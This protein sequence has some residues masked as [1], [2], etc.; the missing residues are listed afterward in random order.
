MKIARFMGLVFW[1]ISNIHMYVKKQDVL[2]PNMVSQVST[3]LRSEVKSILSL[4]FCKL[5][6]DTI[7]VN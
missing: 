2:F 4:K 5:K 7:L 1:K 6:T 3:G